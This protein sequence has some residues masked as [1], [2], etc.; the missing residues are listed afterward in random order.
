M[1]PATL[2]FHM[3]FFLH[4]NADLYKHVNDMH[5]IQTDVNDAGSAHMPSLRIYAPNLPVVFLWRDESSLHLSGSAFATGATRSGLFIYYAI[6]DAPVTVVGIVVVD[7]ARRVDITRV[8]GVRR[9]RSVIE[10]TAFIL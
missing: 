4:L 5:L 2:L 6:W 7:R 9:V 1:Y 8:V 10:V 3:T